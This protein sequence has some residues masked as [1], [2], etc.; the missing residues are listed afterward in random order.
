MKK[1]AS[2]LFGIFSFLTA[3]TQDAHFSQYN[4][5]RLYTNPAFTGSD[6]TLNIAMNYRLQWPKIDPYQSLCFSADKYIHALRGGLGLNYLY[7]YQM[8][9]AFIKTR[10]DLNYAP[11]FELFHHKLVLQP[12]IQVS[13]FQNKIDFSKLTFGDQIDDRRGF[14]YNTNEMSGQSTKSGI[15]FSAG[16]L[17]YSDRYFGGVAF[18]HLSQPDEGVIGVSKLPLKI[19]AH[20][21][22]NL[23]F[24][25]DSARKLIFSPTLLYIQQGDFSMLL[26]GITVKYKLIS[27]G[28]SYRAHDAFITTLAFQNRFLRIGYSYDY[29]TS[30]L[31]IK[32]TGGTHELGLTWFINV[33]SKH[34]L[35]Q[36]L[37]LI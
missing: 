29:T 24:S 28:L 13:Y 36:T 31:G 34:H 19:T 5:S 20:A 15:D 14:I 26:P 32:N 17:L 18:H 35:S 30:Q 9:G 8:Q 37:R 1:L 16:L 23:G 4:N 22:A 25:R 11:H 2:L 3:F 7:D 33:K 21:G 6:S 10:V 12:G 27:V